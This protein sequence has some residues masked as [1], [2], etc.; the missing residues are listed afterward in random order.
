MTWEKYKERGLITVKC[1]FCDEGDIKVFYEPQQK[2][3]NLTNTVGGR[4]TKVFRISKEKYDVQN[5]CPHCNAS[6][7][8]IE[9]ALISNVNYNAPSREKILERMRKAGLP[10]RI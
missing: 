3:S 9:K 1:P 7:K 2:R 5:D 6:K 10:T 8:K 4:R